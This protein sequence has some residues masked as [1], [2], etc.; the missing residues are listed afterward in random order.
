MMVAIPLTWL[1]MEVRLE[2]GK[3]LEGDWEGGLD[4]NEKRRNGLSSEFC[5]FASIE[6]GGY[7]LGLSYIDCEI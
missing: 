6:F 3:R 7:W 1:E 2:R 4:L 5:G